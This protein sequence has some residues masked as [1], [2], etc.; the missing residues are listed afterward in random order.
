MSYSS[1]LS[2]RLSETSDPK[3]APRIREGLAGTLNP[4]LPAS[5]DAA[6]LEIGPGAGHFLDLLRSLGYRRMRAIEYDAECAESLKARHD[7]EHVLDCPGFLRAHPGSF[8]LIVLLNVVSHLDHN[9]LL[10]LLASSRLALAPGG[11]VIIQ[12]FNAALPSAFYTMANDFTHRIAFTEYSLRQ[13]LRLAGF[14]DITV[15]GSVLPDGGPLRALFKFARAA[16]NLGN[17][18]RLTLERGAGG[19]PTTYAKLLLAVAHRP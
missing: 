13:V 9:P 19:N 18:L 8:D 10:E 14:V 17:R 1:Y 7:V 11:K 5:M 15:R 12:T 3:H 4:E 6:I 16:L 2:S